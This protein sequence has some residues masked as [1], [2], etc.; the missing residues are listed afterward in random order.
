[1][2]PGDKFLTEKI[3]IL[4]PTTDHTPPLSGSVG[5]CLTSLL[6]PVEQAQEMYVHVTFDFSE[7]G[8]DLGWLY[9][10]NPAKFKDGLPWDSSS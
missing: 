4:D 10:N 6:V 3:Y 5:A 8:H 9:G 2:L 1:M 7:A